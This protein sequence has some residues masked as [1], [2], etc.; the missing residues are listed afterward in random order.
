M[1]TPYRLKRVLEEFQTNWA[2]C[3]NKKKIFIAMDLNS[4][5]EELR[6][7]TPTELLA[8]ISDV[9][10]EFVMIISE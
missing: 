2:I 7:G 5:N 10:R 6:R 1:D 3:N 4:S 8:V 9:R